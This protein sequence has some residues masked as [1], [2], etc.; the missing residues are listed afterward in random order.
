MC[1]PRTPSPLTV[2]SLPAGP[3]Q[4]L[5]AL[6][7]VTAR[8]DRV[9][10]SAWHRTRAAATGAATARPGTHT[11]PPGPAR[12][13]MTPGPERNA[14]LRTRSDLQTTTMILLGMNPRKYSKGQG[15][16]ATGGLVP[17]VALSPPLHAGGLD[18]EAAMVG[19]RQFREVKTEAHRPLQASN[20]NGN[21]NRAPASRHHWSELTATR[22]GV[23]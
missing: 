20:S 11:G 19:A 1:R 3:R 23:A 2:D 22:S 17:P 21:N 4:K 7:T 5:T 9:P 8:V 16:G 13:V 12:I 6:V 10:R 14:A 18:P 15:L